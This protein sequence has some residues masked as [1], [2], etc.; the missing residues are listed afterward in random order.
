[1]GAMKRKRRKI[2]HTAPL[3]K[4]RMGKNSLLFTGAMI[5]ASLHCLLMQRI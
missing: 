4:K 3:N 1:M 5:A 2:V